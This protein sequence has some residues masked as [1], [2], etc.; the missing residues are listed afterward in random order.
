MYGIYPKMTEKPAEKKFNS[1]REWLIAQIDECIAVHG[2]DD[3][4]FGYHCL[5]DSSMVKR[6]RN[7]GD[8]TTR[9]L[10]ITVKFLRNPNFNNQKR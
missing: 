1:T 9:K 7:G 2:V 10:D 8:I 6:L 5:K 3:E 4:S